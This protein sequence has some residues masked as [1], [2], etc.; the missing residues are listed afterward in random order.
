M[1][2]ESFRYGKPQFNKHYYYKSNS[3]KQQLFKQKTLF[4]F[5]SCKMSFNPPKEN[6]LVKEVI[7]SGLK[8]PC[9]WRK[10][11]KEIKM[12]LQSDTSKLIGS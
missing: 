2:L 11:G 8:Y 5:F 10:L 3:C 12:L 4:F 6:P 1:H 7:C 9:I